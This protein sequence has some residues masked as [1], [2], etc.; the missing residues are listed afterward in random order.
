MYYGLGT[1]HVD[2]RSAG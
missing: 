2:M 1:V